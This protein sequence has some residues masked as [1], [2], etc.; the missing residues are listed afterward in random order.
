MASCKGVQ[1]SLG[2]W[3]STPSFPD[4]T[5]WIPDPSLEE[6]GFRILIVR[7]IPDSLNCIK[8]LLDSLIWSETKNIRILQLVFLFNVEI[9]K[10]EKEKAMT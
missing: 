1:V 6:L 3:I 2:Y 7:G 4:S 10:F 5:Y 9:D 8:N